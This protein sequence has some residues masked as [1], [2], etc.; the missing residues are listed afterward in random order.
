[1]ENSIQEAIYMFEMKGEIADAISILENVAAE[2]DQEDKESAYFYL[3]KIQELSGNTTSSNFYYKQSLSRTVETSKSYWLAE[4]SAATSNQAEDF[5]QSPILLKSKI[6]QTFGTGPTFCLFQDGAIGRI[7]NGEI[8]LLSADYPAGSLILHINSKGYWYASPNNDSLH[9]QQFHAS[10]PRFS[11]AISK[12]TG[13]LFN[14]NHAAIQTATQ[15]YIINKKGV[16]SSIAEKYAGCSIEN[17]F[18]PTNDYIL[19]CPDNALH[20][21]AAENGTEKQSLAQF[22]VIQKTLINKDLLFLVSNGNLYCYTPK[23]GNNP[24]WKVSVNNVESML[25]FGKDLAVL[26]ASGKMYLLDQVSGFIHTSIRSDATKMYPLAQGTLGLFSEEGSI[27]SV[28]TLLF[29]LWNFSFTASTEMPPIQ[30]EDGIYLYMGGKK[31]YPILPQYYGKRTLRSELFAHKAATLCEREMWDSLSPVLDTLLNLEPGNAEGWFF[32]ALYLEKNN[33][34][35]KDKQKA[36]S[37][38]VRLSAS[39]PRVTNLILSRYGKAIGAKHVNLL[40]I[41]PKTRYPQLFGNKKDLFTIDPAANRLFC[42]STETGELKW[43]KNLGRLENGPVVSSDDKNLVIASGYKV[44]FFE[45]SKET[46]STSVQLPGKAFDVKIYDNAT[47]I[48]TWNG[49]LLK[50]MK[51]DNK[52]AWSRKIYSVPFFT[53]KDHGILYTSNL[54]GEFNALDDASGQIKDGYTKRL[55]GPITHMVFADTMI[56]IATGNNRLIL[57]NPH[58]K[59][60]QPVQVLMESSIV[61][62][63]SHKLND[64]SVLVM[65]LSDQSVLMY[66]KS[67]API[68]KYKGKNSIFTNPFVKGDEIWIDHGSEIVSISL[69]EGKF[70]RKFSTPGGAG[71]PFVMNHTLFSVSPK[72]VLYGFSL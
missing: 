66:S 15:F 56:A 71:S 1:M 64:E 36:W 13:T 68:W 7:E 60:K 2:G 14:E 35:E 45:L 63:Q 57:L 37:E 8:N 54:E 21:V 31:L 17:F 44:N 55:Q 34:N 3:G 61:S 49:F 11:Y 69:Q 70:L 40:P 59:E 22:D 33:G 58:N 18:K 19:N 53:I 28:D 25:T 10:T 24:V 67:G 39:N 4:R 42:I 20:F 41:S 32:K 48:A 50:I 43:S 9:F 5:L 62:L 65:G 23:K 29:P 27:T 52:L 30:T 72:R 46:A 6:K 16:V 12:I 38:A 47:Y 26:E 51:P